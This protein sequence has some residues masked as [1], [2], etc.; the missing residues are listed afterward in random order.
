MPFLI[1]TNHNLLKA[2]RVKANLEGR[3]IQFAEKLSS[4]DYNIVYRPGKE[5]V[6]ADLL[7]R[8]L[9]AIPEEGI[10]GEMDE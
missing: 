2:L 9:T 7:S 6:L 4:Y 10:P 3:I 5:N 8:A 1:V